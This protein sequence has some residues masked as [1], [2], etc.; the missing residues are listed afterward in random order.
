MDIT[1]PDDG[2]S[3]TIGSMPE[4][5]AAANRFQIFEKFEKH[6]KRNG[7]DRLSGKGRLEGIIQQCKAKISL[8][9]TEKFFS[10][11]ESTLTLLCFVVITFR[12]TGQQLFC[13]SQQE[14]QGKWE[15]ERG[16]GKMRRRKR[17]RVWWYQEEFLDK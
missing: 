13:K 5:I 2:Y 8:Y 6:N 10:L 16:K 17:S 3:I 1:L 11:K 7:W 4:T 15:R 12:T 9:I 14:S